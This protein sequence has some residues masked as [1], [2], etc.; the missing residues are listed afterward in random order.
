MITKEYA[1]QFAYE[2]IAAWNSHD[3][4]RILSHYADDFEF[5][6][7]FVIQIV[8]EPSGT[9]TG[10]QAVGAYWAKGLA[11]LPDLHFELSSVLWGVRT[12]VIHYRRHDGRMAAE[13][14][15]FGEPSGKVTRSAAQYAG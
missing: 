5:S 15:E 8:G 13:W 10:K 3:L 14:F 11:R 1:E 2:W 7:P 4:E 12:L 6:S 9:L